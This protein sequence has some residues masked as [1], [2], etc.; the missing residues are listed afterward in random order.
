[1]PQKKRLGEILIEAGII[2]EEQLERALHLQQENRKLLG[3]ILVEMGWVAEQ[4]V[5]RAVAKVLNIDYVSV[6]NALVS[7]EVVQLIP[8]ALAAKYNV[9]PLFIQDKNLY[10]AMENALDSDIMQQ[11]ETSTGMHVKS[12][13]APPIQL[14]KAV[15]RHYNI[16]EYLGSMLENAKGEEMVS[17]EVSEDS[18]ETGEVRKISEENQIVRFVNLIIANGIRERASSI[19]I[20]PMSKYVTMWYK[21]DGM[22]TGG[23]SIP[24][25]VQSS[26][27]STI[28]GISGMGIAEHRAFQDGGFTVRYAQRK[29]NLYVST[30]VAGFG[31]NIIIRILDRKMAFHHLNRLGLSPEHQS[32]CRMMIHQPQGWIVVTGP[33]GC[34]KT[35]TLYALLNAMKGGT[36]KIVTLENPVEYEL[37]GID[38][39]QI[40]PRVEQAFSRGLRSLLSQKPNVIFVGEIRD[41]ETAIL[42]LQALEA[43]YLV[44]SPLHASDVVSTVRRLFHLGISPDLVAS[45][46]LVVIAQRLVRRI[47]P[48]CKT[49]HVPTDQELQSIGIH[50]GHIPPFACYKGGGC[51]TC[52]Y[53][54]YLGQTGIYEI[55]APNDRLRREIMRCPTKRTLKQL[56][57]E[58]GMETM[59]EDGIKKIRHGITT[60]EEVARVCPVEPDKPEGTIRCPGC[61]KDI[62]ETENICP[63]CRSR[64][65]E[66]CEQCGAEL[67]QEWLVCPF[68]EAQKWNVSEAD[69]SLLQKPQIPIPSNIQQKNIRI[70]VAESDESTRKMVTSLLDRQ[71]YEVFTAVNGEDVLE[72]IRIKLPDLILLDP[73]IPKR[74]G[75][76]VCKAIRSGVRTMFIPVVMLTKQNSIE[77]KVR[78]LSLGANEYITKPFEPDALLAR[79]EFVLHH[80]YQREQQE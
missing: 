13:I 78:G 25:W 80:L 60:V 12:L 72:K 15:R 50:N 9:L 53:T 36:K 77:E 26:L 35:T 49:K 59:L 61:G 43:G 74:D 29:I 79:I 22:L 45:N 2:N 38:Q 17:V 67:E 73:N 55:F 54:G 31:E 18:I 14:Q 32:I 66:L 39:F 24:K 7:Q 41:A 58:A 6:D 27:I 10:L 40:N 48:E 68:C 52:K 37:E 46:L 4:E 8:E 65:Y 21:I 20:E 51:K 69:L 1:M 5:C 30:L 62:M 19:H 3:Q 23:I 16:D 70:V 75:F 28:K 64:L 76:S 42:V 56:A 44:L 71:G 34:G 11:I 33:P 57:I 63:F 47:C